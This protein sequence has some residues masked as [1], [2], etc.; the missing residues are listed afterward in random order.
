MPPM[1]EVAHLAHI[2]LRTPVP[3][4]SL[5]FF[6]GYLGLTATGSAGDS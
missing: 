5:R 3:D 6:T 1:H 2:E 4:E